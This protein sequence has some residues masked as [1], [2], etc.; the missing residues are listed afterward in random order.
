MDKEQ[1]LK[2]AEDVKA[3]NRKVWSQQLELQKA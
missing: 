1:Q 2:L 3:Q